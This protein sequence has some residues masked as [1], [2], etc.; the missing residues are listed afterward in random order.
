[1]SQVMSFRV[2]AHSRR[3]VFAAVAALFAGSAAAQG[4]LEARYGVT[5]AG[6]NVGTADFTLDVAGDRYTV[7]ASGRAAGMLSA[8][9][10]GEG[11]IAATGAL[12]HGR[13][14]P[15]TFSSRIV[16]DDDKADTTMTIADGTVVKLVAET[17]TPIADRVP[18]MEEHRRGIVDPV[19]ALL[20]PMT[21]ASG[22]IGKDA[23]ERTLPVFDGRRR[24]DLTLTFKRMDKVKADKGY[25]GPVAVCAVTF[26]ARAGHRSS[27]TLVKFL[28]ERDIELALAPVAGARLLAPYRVTVASMF[29][30]LVV[31]A[32]QFDVTTQTAAK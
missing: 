23:C 14:S 5:M 20:V 13:P 30:N 7:A 24:Y 17:P 12:R 3:I 31:E 27:S 19:T 9:V 6:L 15:G 28:S 18:V 21:A 8:L 32:K 1:M 2:G 25:A 29:G 11:A 4:K 26:T 10:N 22:A 16:R